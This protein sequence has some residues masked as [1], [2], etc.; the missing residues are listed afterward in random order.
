MQTLLAPARMFACVARLVS[1]A[2]LAL[3]LIRPLHA[4]DPGG[5][6][7][8]VVS[9][10]ATGNLLE[11]AKVTIDALGLTALTD[12]TGRYVLTGVPPGDHQVAASYTGLDPETA[13]VHVAAGGAVVQTFALGSSVYKLDKF[14][15]SGPREGSASAITLQRNAPNVMNVVAM[16]FFGNLPNMSAGEVAIR[17]PGVAGQLDDENNVTGLIIRGQP[18]TNNRVLVD[19]FLLASSAGASRQFQT[20]SLTG[21]M[22]ENLEVIKGQVPDFSADSV[23]GSVNLQ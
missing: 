6:V 7:T 3:V 8:G 9:N 16:D 10:S 21:A 23:G 13:G 15:V 20:H 22:F 11:G 5:S 2:G 12:H 4:A 19:G 14:T 17:L 18:S 1:V